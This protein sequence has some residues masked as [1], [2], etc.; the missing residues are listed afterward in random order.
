MN[1]LFKERTPRF[2]GG[3]LGLSIDREEELMPLFKGLGNNQEENMSTEQVPNIELEED[4]SFES[5][6]EILLSI[7]VPIDDSVKLYLKE[8]GKVPL[9]KPLEE[10][11][12][13]KTILKGGR[14]SDLAKRKLIQANLRLVV[15]IA[16]RYLG[17]GLNFLDLIQEGNIGL[18]KAAEKFDSE[19]GFKFSTYATWWIKQSI[20]RAIADKAHTIRVPVH[21]VENLYKL[22][23]MS[24]SL[25]A[26]LNRKPTED[27]LAD[28]MKVSKDRLD[29]ILRAV[30]EPVSLETPYGKE[31]DAKLGDFIEDSTIQRPDSYV[32]NE[33][34]RRDLNEALDGLN[35]RERHVINLRFGLE[36]GQQRSLDEISD[37]F[38]MPRERVKQ[39]EFKAL[40]KLRHPDRSTKLK[41]YLLETK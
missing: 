7:N 16:K 38:K 6:E 15:S 34:L 17:R 26:Q 31:D 3:R 21:M 28:A 27:E 39:I 29:E 4:K 40:R 30:K 14:S 18:M 9:L 37:L 20:T 19:R 35:E 32:S 36:D 25:T 23:R 13:S 1:K 8:I 10:L 22:R 33:L 11:E 24:S 12:L 41:D 5:P 2:R